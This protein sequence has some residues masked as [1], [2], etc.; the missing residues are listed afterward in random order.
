MNSKLLK[1]SN[2]FV[3]IHNVFFYT[4]IFLVH[5]LYYQMKSDQKLRYLFSSNNIFNICAN[6]KPQDIDVIL[7]LTT[8][9]KDHKNYL[10]DLIDKDRFA[11]I[12]PR[13]QIGRCQEI[14]EHYVEIIYHNLLATAACDQYLQL[15]EYGKMLS[16]L[17]KDP[18]FQTCY[19]YMEVNS[20]F[21]KDQIGTLLHGEGSDKFIVVTGPKEDAI[22]KCQ[23]I[24]SYT[25]EDCKDLS[26]ITNITNHP[27]E[28]IIPYYPFNAA[29]NRSKQEIE[30]EQVLG[31]RLDFDRWEHPDTNT[32]ID[33]FKKFNLSVNTIMSPI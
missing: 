24:D 32:D 16:L 33:F 19:L 27:A 12:I 28:I 11:K 10:H 6:A 29:K 30:V 23:P 21:V 4:D 20:I 31:P 26:I 8:A 1:R 22:K 14:L 13:H 3:D 7:K 5:E 25:F 15:T 18:N 2:L 9:K 17:A